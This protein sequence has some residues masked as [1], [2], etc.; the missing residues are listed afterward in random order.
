MTEITA[1]SMPP[2]SFTNRTLAFVAFVIIA[3]VLLAYAEQRRDSDPETWTCEYIIDAY[4]PREF[5][6]LLRELWEDNGYSAELT[7]NG[8]DGGVDV[9]ASKRGVSVAIEAKQYSPKNTVGR[10]V[11]QKVVSASQQHGRSKATVVTT[12]SFTDPAED[13]C[14]ALRSNSGVSVELVDGDDLV[15]R[16]NNSAL[17]PGDV[18]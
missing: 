10:P 3:F 16:L 4:T 13:A 11:V 5:E 9:F 8:A 14:D 7:S 12:S 6:A 17:N 15:A 18:L 1:A 2:V